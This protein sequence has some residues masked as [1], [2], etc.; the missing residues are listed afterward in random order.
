M[1]FVL[2]LDLNYYYKFH[3]EVITFTSFELSLQQKGDWVAIKTVL[4]Y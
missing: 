2:A 4:G 3:S 1:T